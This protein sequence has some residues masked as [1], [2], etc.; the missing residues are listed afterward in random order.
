MQSPTDARWMSNAALAMVLALAG[1]GV[2][3]TGTNEAAM[4]QPGPDSGWAGGIVTDDAGG[5][6]EIAVGT[7]ASDAAA[8]PS[9]PTEVGP[10]PPVLDPCAIMPESALDSGLAAD[11]RC[12]TGSHDDGTG[13]CVGLGCAAGYAA[14]S[15]GTC[16]APGACAAGTH[17]AGDGSCVLNVPCPPGQLGDCMGACVPMAGVVW[18]R[19]SVSP[20]GRW[21]GVASSA[22]GTKLVAV[23]NG[24]SIY[25]S[26]NSGADWV[27]RGT[28]QN[29]QSV[30][31]SADGTKLVAVVNGC[32]IYSSSNS[33]ADWVRRGTPQS[34]RSVASSADG[35]K[36]VAL[37]E[38]GYIYTSSNS[39]ADWVQQGAPRNWRGVAS[40][41][42]GT[43][44]VAVESPGYI[45]TSSGPVP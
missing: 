22:D 40:S 31:S 30:A 32:S 4:G 27:P 26:S 7:G 10:D 8:N 41:A 21:T 2:N 9:W 14:G 5:A 6:D 18:T 39:G 28:P 29:W 1:C 3:G 42:D 33:G 23:V 35:T 19:A 25:T 11:L 37:V 38:G 16:L 12:A 36:L 43:K 44:L 15:D 17:N 13:L 20:T 34:W 45:Y 24:G